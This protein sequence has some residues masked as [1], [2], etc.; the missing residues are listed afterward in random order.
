[1]HTPTN[2]SALSTLL[3]KQRTPAK[4]PAQPTVR[5]YISRQITAADHG[6]SLQRSF[7]I[8]EATL[9]SLP[10]DADL[11]DRP[12]DGSASLE[13]EGELRCA[14][15]VTVGS[16]AMGQLSVKVGLYRA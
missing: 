13:Y 6:Y 9:R 4:P 11:A 3:R 10:P 12:Y 16:F 5:I 7:K 14:E 1:M 2:P 8:G 15:N